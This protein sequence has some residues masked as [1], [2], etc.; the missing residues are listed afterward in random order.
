MSRRLGGKRIPDQKYVEYRRL[1]GR[2][3]YEDLQAA[4]SDP[5]WQESDDAERL[6]WVDQIKRD[7]R[8]DARD[9][10]R[11][12][13]SNAPEDRGATPRAPMPPPP[14]AGFEMVR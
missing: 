11:L 10:L 6:K 3:T 13:E 2:Y 7:A 5:E 1:A 9:E 8:A 14:P 12:G 4:I